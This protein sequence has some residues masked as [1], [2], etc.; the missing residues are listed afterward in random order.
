MIDEMSPRQARWTLYAEISRLAVTALWAHKLRTLLTMLGVIFGVA[1]VI[2]MLA[3]GKGAE[4]EAVEQIRAFGLHNVILR[5]HKLDQETLEKA[6]RLRSVGLSADDG[7]Y[8][9]SIL[10]YV[11][12]QAPQNLL[13]KDVE[14]AGLKPHANLVGTT[15]AYLSVASAQ[16][17]RGRFLSDLD[18]QLARRVCVI[19]QAISRELF[20]K[21]SS[22]GATLSIGGQRFTVVGVMADKAKTKE[23][24]KIKSRN[25][26]EDV[27]IPLSSAGKFTLVDKEVSDVNS[28]DYNVVDEIVLKLSDA[29]HMGEAKAVIKK[30]LARRHHGIE[31]TELIVP[32]ELL[33]QSQQTQRLFNFVM[34]SIAGLSLL[35]GGIGIMNIMLA[36]VTERTREIGL[37]KALGAREK[38]ILFLIESVLIAGT[39][40]LVGVVFGIVLGHLITFAVGWTTVITLGSI[41]VSFGVSAAVGVFFGYWPA[42]QAAALDPIDALRHE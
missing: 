21:E 6:K 29:D 42:K 24:I 4:Q 11:D 39:G 36:T 9:A 26:N 3:I 31:D 8:I 33:A 22:L 14:H 15:P 34:A 35:V 40:G 38:D 28:P 27:Y 16:V 5:A 12:A 2:A 37:R 20:F 7:E 17:E 30:V 13:D 23:K 41:G 18:N 25:T 1:A 10:P 32:D 19:G